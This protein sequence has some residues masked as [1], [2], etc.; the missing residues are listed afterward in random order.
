LSG[1]EKWVSGMDYS[2]RADRPPLRAHKHIPKP[3]RRPKWRHRS[4]SRVASLSN[5]L[6]KREGV[7]D[8]VEGARKA[9]I[10]PSRGN[11]ALTHCR[12]A[13]SVQRKGGVLLKNG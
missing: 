7:W 13:Q 9:A 2:E 12:L 8:M 5:S 1:E 3:S 11:H 4:T 10:S 6:G